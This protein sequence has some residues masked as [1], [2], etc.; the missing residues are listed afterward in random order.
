MKKRH[1]IIVS[2]VLVVGI[3]VAGIAFAENQGTDDRRKFGFKHRHKGGGLMLLAKYQQKNLMIQVLSEMTE[4]SADAIDAKIK[5][6]GMRGV[7]QELNIDRQ[8]FHNAMQTKVKERI[9]EAVATGTITAEQEKAILDKMEN[10]AQRREIISR[11]IEKG[12]EDGTI[13]QRQAE[14]LVRKPR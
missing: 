13:T 12:L 10:R 5:D 3:I 14:M 1:T 8:A 6:Q 9:K 2:C 7:M 4:Q 11:L